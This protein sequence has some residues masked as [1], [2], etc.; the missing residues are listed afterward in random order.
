MSNTFGSAPRGE[1][2]WGS[3]RVAGSPDSAH[4][5]ART[6][7][8]SVQTVRNLAAEAEPS[9]RAVRAV[10]ALAGWSAIAQGHLL[11]LV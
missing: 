5:G 7:R 3:A 2:W 10:R 8:G 4:C 6:V 1:Q 11:L 9:L